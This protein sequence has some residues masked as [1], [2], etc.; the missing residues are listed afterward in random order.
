MQTFIVPTV[1]AS[2]RNHHHNP[3]D[4]TTSR[5]SDSRRA[6]IASRQAR[7]PVERSLPRVAGSL[8]SASPPVKTQAGDPEAKERERG[9]LGYGDDTVSGPGHLDATA[10][11]L[12]ELSA[13]PAKWVLGVGFCRYRQIHAG[14]VTCN[15]RR[16]KRQKT[17]PHKVHTRKTQ[18]VH[19]LHPFCCRHLKPL[20]Y[21]NSVR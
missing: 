20:L 9:G 5:L 8:R 21:A 10:D 3:N 4:G 1:P 17:Q 14:E 18:T 13:P 15:V 12:G 2:P 16:R 7:Q 19:L 11:R 6:S